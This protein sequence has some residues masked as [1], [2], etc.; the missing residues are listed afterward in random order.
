MPAKFCVRTGCYEV[1]IGAARS[2]EHC[3]TH[4]RDVLAEAD[5]LVLAEVT[6][7]T[8]G[9]RGEVARVTCCVAREGRQA[10]ERV[11]LDPAETNV[12]ALVAAGAVRVLSAGPCP[13]LRAPSAADP[14]GE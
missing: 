3:S 5:D 6:A 12:A 1:A 4:Y 9:R 10:P 2:R 7:T 14:E 8:S 11:W 13:D